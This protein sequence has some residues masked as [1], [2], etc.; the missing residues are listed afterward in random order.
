MTHGSTNLGHYCTAHMLEKSQN[1]HIFYM[2]GA[3]F[4]QDKIYILR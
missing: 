2:Y 1:G 3:V 4:E